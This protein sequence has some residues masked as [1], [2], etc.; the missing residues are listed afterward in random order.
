MPDT[1]YDA[2]GNLISLEEAIKDP[3]S[4]VAKR[5]AVKNRDDKDAGEG[6]DDDSSDMDN[7]DEEAPTDEL[8][9]D[10]DGMDEFEEFEWLESMYGEAAI[11]DG[12]SKKNSKRIAYCIAKLSHRRQIQASFYADMEEPTRDT[13]ALVY[14]LFDGL[15]M[16]QEGTYRAFCQEGL[17]CLGEKSLTRETS[18]SSR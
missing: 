3:L 6:E 7:E 10:R 13:S 5:K 17:R 15:R 12:T 4:D 18:F 9:S 11:T 2:T 1:S 16:P 8:L 14:D